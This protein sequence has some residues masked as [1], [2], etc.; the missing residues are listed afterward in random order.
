MEPLQAQ[1]LLAQWQPCAFKH[2][3]NYLGQHLLQWTVIAFWTPTM[4]CFL[5]WPCWMGRAEPSDT[6]NNK[7]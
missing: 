5:T 3:I 4:L 7:L 1:G 2:P 6:S